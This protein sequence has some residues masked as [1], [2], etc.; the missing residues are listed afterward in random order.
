[1]FIEGNENPKKQNTEKQNDPGF[2]LWS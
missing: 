1:M 2:L